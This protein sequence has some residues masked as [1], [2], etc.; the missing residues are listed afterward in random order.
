MRA[1]PLLLWIALGLGEQETSPYPY[2][3]PENL[4][5]THIA[6]INEK[7]MVLWGRDSN[8]TRTVELGDKVVY[9]KADS[10]GKTSVRVTD[11]EYL[12]SKIQKKEFVSLKL[13]RN[14]KT[15]QVVWD[16]IPSGTP[17]TM[18]LRPVGGQPQTSQGVQYSFPAVCK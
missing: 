10:A 6:A 14:L 2:R 5:I 3:G 16:Y 1:L 13:S 4:V 17:Y 12:K 15:V 11:S 8:D 18:T 9:C 7:T